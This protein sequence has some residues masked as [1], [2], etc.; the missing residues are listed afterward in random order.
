MCKSG[1]HFVLWLFGVWVGWFS[2][3]CVAAYIL[4]TGPF[5]GG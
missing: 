5:A 4:K 3:L 1:D 2:G